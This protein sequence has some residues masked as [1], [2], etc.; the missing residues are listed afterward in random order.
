MSESWKPD[1]PNWKDKFPDLVWWL[2]LNDDRVPRG[3]VEMETRMIRD[4]TTGEV[5]EMYIDHRGSGVSKAIRVDM[6]GYANS[7]KFKKAQMRLEVW[8]YALI[9]W[10]L[11]RIVF[12]G[13]R[14]IECF[15]IIKHFWR[16]LSGQP[17]LVVQSVALWVGTH[18]R[19]KKK[20]ILWP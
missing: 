13:W 6:D 11:Q 2:D 17:P 7:F 4:S 14:P 19:Y 12:E 9:V 1:F 15:R 18:K 16:N 3:T 10:C 5:W 8:Q 20:G